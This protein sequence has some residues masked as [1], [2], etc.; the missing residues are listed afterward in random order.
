MVFC[1]G[2]AGYFFV[3]RRKRIRHGPHN[4]YEFE[5]LDDE[6]ETRN[7]TGGRPGKKVGRKA[8]ELYDAFAGGSEEDLVSSD[9]EDESYRDESGGGEGS[10]GGETEASTSGGSSAS[11]NPP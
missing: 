10:S 9:E 4:D 1:A 7:L 5:I 2:L 3:Q 6:E 8:G 11:P